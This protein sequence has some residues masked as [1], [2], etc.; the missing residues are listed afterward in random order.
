[1]NVF[2]IL[3][4]VLSISVRSL[5]IAL[6]RSYFDSRHCTEARIILSPGLSGKSW[7][8]NKYCGFAFTAR[9]RNR[10]RYRY[11]Q[12]QSEIGISISHQ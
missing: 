7:R 11:R 8:K 4:Q 3:M 2:D 5:A 10:N 9:R 6:K 12:A 1:V